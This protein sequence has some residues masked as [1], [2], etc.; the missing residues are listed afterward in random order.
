MN[1]IIESFT[2]VKILLINR[3]QVANVTEKDNT[4]THLYII[5]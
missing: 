1:I 5:I 2:L 4:L 3:F